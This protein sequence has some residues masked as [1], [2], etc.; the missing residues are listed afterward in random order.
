MI[1]DC[2]LARKPVLWPRSQAAKGAMIFFSFHV[3]PSHAS[4][5]I[6]LPDGVYSCITIFPAFSALEGFNSALLN[7]SDILLRTENPVLATAE[8]S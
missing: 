7:A 5:R 8:Y 4:P 6:L 3:F 2:G 1:L